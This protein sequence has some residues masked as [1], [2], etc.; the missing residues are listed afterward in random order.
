MTP[1][2]LAALHPVEPSPFVFVSI[3]DGLSWSFV[4]RCAFVPL[5]CGVRAWLL[6]GTVSVAPGMPSALRFHLRARSLSSLL[7][8]VSAAFTPRLPTAACRCPGLVAR[9]LVSLF[10][11]RR[12]ELQPAAPFRVGFGYIGV[13]FDLG[14]ERSSLGL[15]LGLRPAV[16]C[17]VAALLRE[18]GAVRS[19]RC[20]TACCRAVVPCPEVP[21]RAFRSSA[22]PPSICT[23]L[24]FADPVPVCDACT[25]TYAMNLGRLAVSSHFGLRCAQLLL[26]AC[27][28]AVLLAPT[29]CVRCLACCYLLPA[30]AAC[31]HLLVLTRLLP[32]TCCCSYSR[33][34]RSVETQI[35]ESIP[36][37]DAAVVRC[38]LAPRSRLPCSLLVYQ[39]WI[40]ALCYPCLVFASGSAFALTV[41]ASS[42]PR[43]GGVCAS[44][45]AM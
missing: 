42:L 34:V 36:F 33:W 1:P 40:H 5:C 12:V 11:S 19:L 24:R 15:I 41:G 38:V 2:E 14:C 28:R 21:L 16:L 31:F 43:I 22:F 13:V 6:C 26:P 4:D 25:G 30:R 8:H 3:D 35:F 45:N 44:M 32:L 9:L 39:R 37:G 7:P 23:S 29:N 17:C 20:A 10:L 27:R 18:R